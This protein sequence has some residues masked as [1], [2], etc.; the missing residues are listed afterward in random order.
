VMFAA[1]NRQA[2]HNQNCG[3]GGVQAA[4]SLPL[5]RLRVGDWLRR[6]SA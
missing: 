6:S 3:K 1:Q 4:V 2:A 5:R